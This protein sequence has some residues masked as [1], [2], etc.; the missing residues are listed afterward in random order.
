MMKE[1]LSKYIQFSVEYVYLA[2][3]A[4]LTAFVFLRTTIWPVPWTVNGSEI[5]YFNEVSGSIPFYLEYVLLGTV[6]LRCLSGGK[7][8]LGYLGFSIILCTITIYAYCVNQYKELLYLVFLILGAKD[9]SFVKI[10]KVYTTVVGILLG[11]T[12]AAALTGVLENVSFGVEGKLAFGLVSST[13][14]AAHVF[15]FFLCCWYIWRKTE[16]IWL[17]LLV[18]GAAFFVYRYGQGRCSTICLLLLAILFV[19]HIMMRKHMR[20]NSGQYTMRPAFACILACSVQLAAIVTL[21]LSILYEF[22]CVWIQKINQLLSDRLE[23]GKRGIS[24]CGFHLWGQNV[25]LRGNW[26]TGKAVGKYFYLDSSYLQMTVMFGILMSVILML[27]F[28]VI[29]YRAYVFRQWVLLL[30]LA[31]LAIHG[32]IEQRLWNIAYCPFLLALFAQYEKN[33]GD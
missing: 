30:I 32:V 28:L 1:R 20:K 5:Q 33:A 18:L 4:F 29:G 19:G 6:L 11:V 22:D 21:V 24:I 2:V 14:F 3:L 13:D 31:L 8:G 25:E 12:I 15:F 26:V 9:I 27:A 7:K 17:A 10:M 23:L 16:K